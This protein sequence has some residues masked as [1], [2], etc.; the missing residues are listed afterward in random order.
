MLT[1]SGA[2]GSMSVQWRPTPGQV[3]LLEF[4]DAAE[5]T[6]VVLD[7]ATGPVVVNVGSAPPPAPGSEVVASFFT[8]G[9]LYRVRAT[10]VRH[11]DNDALLDLELRG[12]E[13]VQQRAAPRAR[14]TLPA[15]LSDLD[16]AA[17]PLS[18]TGETVDVGPGGC[19]VRTALPFPPGSD[20][21][22]SLQLPDG[23]TVVAT[24]AVLQMQAVMGHWEY[25]LVFLSLDDADRL[26][27]ADLVDPGAPAT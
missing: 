15:A 4:D 17:Q 21:T 14:I 12:V 18:V 5:I 6:G 11:P 9:A 23:G 2:E 7:S 19:R 24:A 27:L 13:R 26:R 25:R 16:S 20:P 1:V 8:P 3:A 10:A 22:V